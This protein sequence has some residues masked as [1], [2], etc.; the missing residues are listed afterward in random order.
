MRELQPD[1]TE[2]ECGEQRN[3]Q[4]G[5]RLITGHHRIGDCQRGPDADSDGITGA[6]GDVPQG[7]G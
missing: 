6:D 2:D 1:D 5:D 4:H 7:E 3:L